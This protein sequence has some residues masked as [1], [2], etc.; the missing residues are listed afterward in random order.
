M[1]WRQ[2]GALDQ[3]QAALELRLRLIGLPHLEQDVPLQAAVEGHRRDVVGLLAQGVLLVHVRERLGHLPA[4]DVHDRQR[5]QPRP[6]LAVGPRLRR[7]G[8]ELGRRLVG[9]S[10][11]QQIHGDALVRVDEVRIDR[12]RLPVL[13][14]RVVEPAHLQK[15][16]G[17]RIVGVGVLRDQL[18]VLLERL[19]G[20]RVVAVLP[21]GVAQE[22]VGGRVGRVDLGGLL[23]VL[24]RLRVLLL[25]EVVAGQIEMRPLVVRV[26]RDELIEVFL[27][28]HRVGVCP[29]LGREDQEPLSVGSLVRQA[30]GLVQV[31][32]ELL[33][34]RRRVGEAQLRQREVRV[35]RDCLGEVRDRVGQEQL[36]ELI[37]ALQELR[38]R[39]GRGRR[40][41]D[42]PGVGRR[43]RLGLDC[44]AGAGA[45]FFAQPPI[46]R[47]DSHSQRQDQ[48]EGSVRAHHV[49][50]RDEENYECA[51]IRVATARL[52]PFNPTEGRLV[53]RE[54]PLTPCEE[55][56]RAGA[57][58]Q[59]TPLTPT[60]SRRERGRISPDA[61][62]GQR[63]SLSPRRGERGRV[64]GDLLPPLPS[65]LLARR[66]H[67]V[68]G[69][70]RPDHH[71]V[72]CARRP[73]CG[74]RGS[75]RKPVLR[76]RFF[77]TSSSLAC[78]ASLRSGAI[79]M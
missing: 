21:V 1:S 38:L 30:H 63:D 23:V 40:H 47:P 43:G 72:A 41:R 20:V 61:V 3:L 76:P 13:D 42:L 55:V 56:S 71:R 10:L 35:E 68:G 28:L 19:F 15:Q 59:G 65:L 9:L 75:R 5:E 50:L 78:C 7:H 64:R 70:H 48:T 14:D 33:G 6:A 8:G 74:T 77:V 73:S 49:L 67:E 17:V 12:Q 22:V 2:A 54:A 11:I 27:L 45:S 69:G 32:E 31:L 29:G 66:R 39:L 4:V 16:L 79:C 26:R 25:A 34:R 46:V 18:D 24:D 44:A 52:V 37:P 58:Q 36:L 51:V 60:L 53:T 62:S 57:E